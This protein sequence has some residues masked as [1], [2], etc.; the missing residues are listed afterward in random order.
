M[1]NEIPWKEFAGLVIMSVVFIV[2]MAVVYRW[3]DIR[4][5]YAKG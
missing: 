5:L 2:I 3:K 1:S 4:K